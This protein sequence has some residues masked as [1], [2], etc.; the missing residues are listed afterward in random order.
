M[1]AKEL[2]QKADREGFNAYYL[3]YALETGVSTPE[4]AFRRDGGNSEFM[5]WIGQRWNETC[6]RIGASHTFRS[7]YFNEHME[8]LAARL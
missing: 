6:D 3:A 4:E 7:V 8:T 1:T 5:M 2:E